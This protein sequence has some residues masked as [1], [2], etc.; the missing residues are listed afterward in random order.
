[1]ERL[2]RMPGQENRKGKHLSEA[3]RGKIEVLYGQ[4]YSPYKIGKLLGRAS[5]T[6]RNELKR[7][8]T[9]IIKDYFEKEVYLA[10]RGQNVY[11]WHMRSCGCSSKKEQC[12]EFLE[13]V[14]QEV[15]E[16]NRSL[17][18]ARGKAVRQGLFPREEMVCTSTLYTYVNRGYLKVKNIDLPEKVERKVKKEECPEKRTH[19]RLKGK[20]I[21]KRPK[22][23]EEKKEFGHWEIDT[24]VGKQSGDSS[25]L[26]T[27]TER[28]TKEEIVR[29]LP[30]KTVEG[31]E[32]ALKEIWKETPYPE[33][34]YK[35]ITS[36]NGTEFSRL[37]K[38]DEQTET[39]VYY[40]HPYSSWERGLNESS[41]RIIRRFVP[42]GTP[43]SRYGEAEIAW[44]EH[45]MNTLPR[46][47]LGY[48]TAEECFREEVEKIVEEEERHFR[49]G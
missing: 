43:I 23:V 29:K 18:A 7:G 38:L 41:N 26:L 21:E 3:E 2:E 49:T 33:K 31:V 1:M 45:W 9:T 5:N 13:Y 40:A 20:S 37:Y 10:E 46:R 34:V 22:A 8:K 30:G 15:L 28:L 47:S 24:V 39:D 36:D 16:E 19:K 25:V 4:G 17:D 14:E 6:I 44:I 48:R 27:L 32:G 12:E 42:K 35:S 11:E